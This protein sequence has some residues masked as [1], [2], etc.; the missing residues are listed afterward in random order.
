MTMTVPLTTKYLEVFYFSTK[1]F[2][3]VPN[4]KFARHPQQVFLVINI[5]FL[6][7]IQGNHFSHN[8]FAFFCHSEL[9]FSNLD[10]SWAKTRLLLFKTLEVS[11]CMDSC[12]VQWRKANLILLSTNIWGNTQWRKANPSLLLTNEEIKSSNSQKHPSIIRVHVV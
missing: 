8:I 10:Q 2:T 6:T 12:I 1:W 4:F 3:C 7:N 5:I 11:N 9:K